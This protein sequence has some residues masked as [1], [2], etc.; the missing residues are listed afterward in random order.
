[1]TDRNHA[2]ERKIFAISD[3][4]N[5]K[6]REA[7]NESVN[8]RV[9]ARANSVMEIEGVGIVLSVIAAIVTALMVPSVMNQKMTI[10]MFIAVATA[11][12]ELS[13]ELIQNVKSI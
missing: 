5:S 13:S 11:I 4:I 1:M 7:C 12:Y 2:N 9:K 3:Y 8:V 10:G 6:W